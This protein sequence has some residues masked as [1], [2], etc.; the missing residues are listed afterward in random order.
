MQW[1]YLSINFACYVVREQIG[2]LL[3]VALLLFVDRFVQQV[4]FRRLTLVQSV[5]GRVRLGPLW[6]ANIIMYLRAI[7]PLLQTY[8]YACTYVPNN[9]ITSTTVAYIALHL[10]LTE[11]WYG[12]CNPLAQKFIQ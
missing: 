10:S 7:K 4:N 8:V 11:K 6:T 3:V 5:F 9:A 2:I 1:L 12:S